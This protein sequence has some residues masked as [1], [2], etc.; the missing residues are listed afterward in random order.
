MQPDD[1]IARG[2][3]FDTQPGQKFSPI[4]IIRKP[5]TLDQ[6]DKLEAG[7]ELDALVAERVMGWSRW[8]EDKKDL[9]PPEGSP[10]NKGWTKRG[11]IMIQALIPEYSTSIE[12]AWRVVEKIKN[13]GKVEKTTDDGKEWYNIRHEFHI[14]WLPDSN[15]WRAGWYDFR[16]DDYQCN[17]IEAPTAP[18]AICKAA[19]KVVI[20]KS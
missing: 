15:M 9:Y 10:E 8:Y 11:G 16:Y 13:L 18:L 7:R 3:L 5:M 19:L 12:A 14:E 20:S 2:K 1:N 4:R 17:D 6:I